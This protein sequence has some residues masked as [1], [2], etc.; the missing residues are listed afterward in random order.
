VKDK[1]SEAAAET[2]EKNSNF[3]SKFIM[4]VVSLGICGRGFEVESWK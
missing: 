1:K 4:K 3:N 2:F